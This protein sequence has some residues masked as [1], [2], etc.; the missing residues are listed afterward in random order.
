MAHAPPVQQFTP[1]SQGGRER[2]RALRHVCEVSTEYYVLDEAPAL[3]RLAWVVNIS[4]SGM[5]L[6]VGHAREPDTLLAVELRSPD[7]CWSYLVTARVVLCFPFQ[8]G[9][10]I[11]C[12]F[13][14]SLRVSELEK[15]L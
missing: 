13:E 7:R 5:A 9:W 1:F 11:G 3:R 2:R 4:T 12:A 15:L 6:V 10:L 8:D 14:R